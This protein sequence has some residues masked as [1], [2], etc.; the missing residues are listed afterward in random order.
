MPT[1]SVLS[2]SILPGRCET[3]FGDV[4][5]QG[6]TAEPKALASGVKRSR[7]AFTLIKEWA[8]SHRDELEANWQRM[9]TGEP[10]KGS[11]RSIKEVL[12]SFSQQLLEPSTV[13][14]T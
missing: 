6:T 4:E 2:S 1:A 10:S 9:R 7:T 11:I 13:A 5:C 8:L 12:W 14:T 3:E